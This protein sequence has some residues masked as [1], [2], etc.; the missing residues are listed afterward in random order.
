MS[1][2]YEL[3]RANFREELVR[4]YRYRSSSSLPLDELYE[5]SPAAR[6]YPRDR[7]LR[8]LVKID[9]DFQCDRIIQQLDLMT[10]DE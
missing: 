1:T 8:R 2:I 10:D 6:R 5:H 4:W 7:V 9:N 3:V